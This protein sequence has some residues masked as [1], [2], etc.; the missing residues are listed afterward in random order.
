MLNLDENI[1][2][3]HTI[4]LI[5]LN[6]NS[7]LLYVTGAN[8]RNKINTLRTGRTTFLFF[9]SVVADRERKFAILRHVTF[10]STV[11][12]FGAT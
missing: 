3:R 11:Q 1:W 4:Y 9:G 5:N 2:S 8:V 6:N 12:W 7:G 10:D